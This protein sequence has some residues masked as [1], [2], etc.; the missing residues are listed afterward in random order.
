MTENKTGRGD[1]VDLL[2]NLNTHFDEK[3]KMTVK[4][5]L[6]DLINKIEHE[7]SHDLDRIIVYGPLCSGDFHTDLSD[8]KIL[9]VVKRKLSQTDLFVL[10]HMHNA[11]KTHYSKWLTRL[12][13]SY[14][15]SSKLYQKEPPKDPRIHLSKAMT[16]NVHYGAEW[17]LEKFMLHTSGYVLYGD[18]LDKD[19]LQVTKINLRVAAFQV[20]MHRWQPMT[21]RAMHHMSHEDLIYGL[22]SMCQLI[23]TIEY[24]L[25][26]S[27]PDAGR[28]VLK[29]QPNQYQ[30]T[31]ENAL[32]YW[33]E[34]GDIEAVDRGAC[35]NFIKQTVE[36]Y[37]KDY[38]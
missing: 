30:N 28:K 14:I 11:L 7:F 26:L 34:G 10:S 18:A 21:Q 35:Y 17:Y 2:V 25:V 15:E 9:V 19:K 31:I 4:N 20:L 33:E 29:D 36:S 37:L 27:R 5:L 32:T 6:T 24:G 22:L 12:E 38:S 13:I 3:D 23:C 16:S 1:Q 8:I